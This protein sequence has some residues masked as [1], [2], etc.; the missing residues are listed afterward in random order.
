MHKLLTTCFLLLSA[1]SFAQ[2]KGKITSADGQGIP[3]VSITIENTYNGTTANE[4]GQ[5]ELAV[6]TTGKYTVIFQSIGFKTQKLSV[7]VKS[8]PHVLNVMMPDENYQL[9][10]VVISN[11]EDP[12]Y[13]VIRQ[14]IAH[15]KENS[16][17]TGRFESDFYSK[18][19]FRI[20]NLPKKFLGQTVEVPDGMVDSTGSGIL[21]LSETVS[22]IT[23]EQPNNLKERIIAS[24]VSGNDNG[25]SFN[26]A[27]NTYYNFYD[28][29]V[30]MS[31]VQVISPIGSG[32]LTYYKYKLEG[33]F[34]DENN[35]QINKIKVTPRR[36]KEAVVEGYIYIVDN[37]WAIYATDFDMKGYRLQTPF[38][39]NLNLKQNYTYNS[40]NGIWAKNSQVF[41]IDAGGFGITFSGSFTHVY[42]NYVFHD[43]FDKK[44]FGKEMIIIEDEANKKDSV[45]WNTM[46]PIPLTEEETI[47]YIKKDSIQT[48]HESVAYKDS[49]NKKYNKF[50]WKD[51]ITGYSYK[52]SKDTRFNYDGILHIPSYNTVQGWVLNTG[53]NAS[54]ALNPE[55]KYDFKKRRLYTGV[56]A[57]YGIAE[58]RVRFSGSASAYNFY[59]SGG[60]T[61]EQFNASN[62]SPF[63]N[64]ISTLF[65]ERNYMK[66]YDKTFAKIAYSNRIADGITATGSVEYLRRRALY[67]NAPWVFIK[68]DNHSYTSNDPLQPYNYSSAPFEKHTLYKASIGANFNFGLKYKVYPGGEKRAMNYGQ[69][70]TLGIKYEKGFAGS[71]KEY[72]YD[73]IAAGAQYRTTFGNKGDFAISLKGGKFFNADGIA[74]T[75]YKHFNANET[76]VNSGGTNISSFNLLPYYSLY[77]NDAYFESHIEHNF[78]G[79]IMN[80]IPLL[81]VLQWNLVVGYHAAATPDSKPYQEFTA[82]FDNIGWGNFRML[83]VDYVR[84]YQGSG[85][86]TDGVMF[87]LKFLD[88][89]D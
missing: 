57:E 40:Q 64:A 66:L 69:Y 36:D 78:K 27:M 70:P 86:A 46:R 33:T 48:L 85:F 54:F 38:L 72:E 55:E 68:D 37:S 80:K 74:F 24:K 61:V 62:I 67:N 71:I 19:I 9:N 32:A 60:N 21:Y 5:Y 56:K 17:K 6:K 82:G 4:Q 22:H 81:N 53:M 59:L 50:N 45:Y 39:N 76:H 49:I 63:V 25:F 89:L 16:A 65:F 18:G 7:D 43:K 10:E 26:T 51:P 77:T 84:A 30:D 52:N 44:T 20:K 88:I 41:D 11:A 28:N 31:E 58:D 8:L 14:A 29:Y 1:A 15:R 42:T 3:F 73:F 34:F 35:N 2:I 12:A 87:G 23:F 75:D 83:R 47:D 13:E 79:Y